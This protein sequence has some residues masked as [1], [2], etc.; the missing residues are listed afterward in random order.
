MELGGYVNSSRPMKMQFDSI[1]LGETGV[2]LFSNREIL[3]KNEGEC[4]KRLTIEEL[5]GVFKWSRDLLVEFED[6]E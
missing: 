2:A 6:D 5:R 4:A 3:V 1:A